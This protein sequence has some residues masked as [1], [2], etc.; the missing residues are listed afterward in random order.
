M[1]TT[2]ALTLAT[3]GTFLPRMSRPQVQGG[4]ARAVRWTTV[5]RIRRDRLNRR[6][7]RDKRFEVARP[8]HQ[9]HF[10]PTCGDELELHPKRL[11]IPTES[12]DHE[13]QLT[14][15]NGKPR[16][17]VGYVSFVE[18]VETCRQT[19]L[20]NLELKES[21]GDRRDR[22]KKQPWTSL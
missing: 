21:V 9:F 18:T 10:V 17:V 5:L 1:L 22:S 20:I 6:A 8:F 4:A 2:R 3:L 12:A 15:R 14:R 16:G 11:R 13:I 19:A 7:A